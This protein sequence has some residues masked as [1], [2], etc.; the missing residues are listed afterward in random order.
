[1]HDVH[2]CTT[3]VQL[4]EAANEVVLKSFAFRQRII[5]A[6]SDQLSEVNF[7]LGRQG[8]HAAELELKHNVCPKNQASAIK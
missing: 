4:I 5:A 8:Q 6:T 3:D 2:R 1:M 7:P